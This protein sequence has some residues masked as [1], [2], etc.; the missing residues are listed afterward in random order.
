MIIIKLL[1]LGD[2]LI[3][4]SEA[5]YTPK[6]LTHLTEILQRRYCNKNTQLKERAEGNP[7]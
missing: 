3:L 7:S 6:I 2:S 5:E 4:M 1:H